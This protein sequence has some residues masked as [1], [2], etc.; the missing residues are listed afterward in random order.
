MKKLST[1]IIE[2]YKISKKTLESREKVYYMIPWIEK[3]FDY[4]LNKYTGYNSKD[5]KNNHFTGFFL[6]K[7]SLDL[8]W[9]RFKIYIFNDSQRFWKI[10]KVPESYDDINEFKKDLNSYKIYI[11]DLEEVA[12]EDI[13]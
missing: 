3:L 2:K 7:E 4:C 6:N 9:K 5:H 8:L 11:D 1:Y 12:H 10:F 13:K